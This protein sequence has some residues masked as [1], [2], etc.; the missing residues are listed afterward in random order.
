MDRKTKWI[1][2]REDWYPSYLPR[3][4]DNSNPIEH[5]AVRVSLVRLVSSKGKG[6]PKWR[7]CVWGADDFGL[8]K[9]FRLLVEAESLFKKLK[10]FATK[11]DMLGL[12]MV[13][14]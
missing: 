6:S 8:E 9:D 13:H 2:T 4:R 14:A 11:L 7:V 10:D 1:K 3:S 12:G 5:R